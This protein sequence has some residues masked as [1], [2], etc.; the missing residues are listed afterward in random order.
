MMKADGMHVHLIHE[1]EAQKVIL[2]MQGYV[3]VVHEAWEIFVSLLNVISEVVTS[4]WSAT[5][6]KYDIPCPHCRML[7][8]PNP[9][10]L[11]SE[12]RE[13]TFDWC[14]MKCAMYT[15]CGSEK[16]VPSLLRGKGMF[17]RFRQCLEIY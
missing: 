3:A 1:A 11:L 13:A 15:Q 8:K 17:K 12:V 10:K 4:A 2:V 16:N 7:R 5:R 9:Q 14:P 6:I